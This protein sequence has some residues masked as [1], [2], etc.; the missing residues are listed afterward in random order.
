MI[1]FGED[2]SRISLAK[3]AFN[4]W[5]LLLS[6]TDSVRSLQSSSQLSANSQLSSDTTHCDQKLLI[7][8]QKKISWKSLKNIF[9]TNLMHSFDKFFREIVMA[10]I[11]ANFLLQKT[12]QTNPGKLAQSVYRIS[13]KWSIIDESHQCVCV[14]GGGGSCPP[15]LPLATCLSYG[16]GLKYLP[17]WVSVSEVNQNICF[18]R[19]LVF[20]IALLEITH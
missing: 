7:I 17:I 8:V 3:P 2:L 10:W 12:Q 9:E 6:N 1:I 5:L 18:S 15:C 11:S 20:C 4:N 14:G 16:I 13:K 19:T